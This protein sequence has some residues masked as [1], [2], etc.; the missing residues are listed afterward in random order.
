MDHPKFREM[1]EVAAASTDGVSIPSRK[2]CRAEI[3]R[4][5]SAQMT[6]LRNKLKVSTHSNNPMAIIYKL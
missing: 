6:H 2:V 1:I 5:F 3:M 4:M